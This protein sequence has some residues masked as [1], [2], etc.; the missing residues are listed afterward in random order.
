MVVLRAEVI[1][2][3][4]RLRANSDLRDSCSK[5]LS[6]ARLRLIF[7]SEAEFPE[8]KSAR[9]ED[10]LLS[11]RIEA[12]PDLEAVSGVLPRCNRPLIKVAAARVA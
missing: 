7:A 2:A 11:N 8:E 5:G 9:R 12:Y 1:I 3:T 4:N 6:P 10:A